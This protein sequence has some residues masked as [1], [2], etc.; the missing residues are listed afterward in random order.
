MSFEKTNILVLQSEN[1]DVDY[2]GLTK[3][4]NPYM[5]NYLSNLSNSIFLY[6]YKFV[7]MS[8]FSDY[9]TSYNTCSKIPL[10][11]GETDKMLLK[12]EDFKNI[13]IHSAT[14]KIF[15]IDYF[16]KETGKKYDF[17][18]YLDSDAWI[19]SP[20]YLNT[21]VEY[22]KKDETKNGAYSRDP[23]MQ[24]NTYINSG[25]FI[26]K[27]NNY[28]FKMYETLIDTIKTNKSH[29]NDWPY[30]QYYIS[31]FVFKNKNDFLIFLPNVLNTPCGIIFRHNWY[32]T[33]KLYRDLYDLL[34]IS[35]VSGFHPPKE[36]IIIENYI[37]NNPFPN[38]EIY[39]YEW[40]EP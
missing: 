34:E 11:E 16:L 12:N 5:C 27:T 36:N 18:I 37:D 15:L 24:Q 17:I 26:I 6:D 21:L 28:I 33:Y 35:Y 8:L 19:Q 22:L 30:D 7:N 4:I 32:K 20:H 38:T 23:Y 39:A 29:L 1:R 10:Q 25:A 14:T 31:N 13:K 3:R 2:L 40:N 9:D